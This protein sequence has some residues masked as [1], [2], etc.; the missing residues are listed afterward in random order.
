MYA[1][2]FYEN[3][4]LVLSQLLK[5]LPSVDEN[6]KIKGRKGKVLSVTHKEENIVHINIEYEKIIKKPVAAADNKKKRR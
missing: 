3:R 5:Q 6:I 2:Y 1:V 4:V